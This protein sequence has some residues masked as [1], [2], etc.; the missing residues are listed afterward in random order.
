MIDKS[1]PLRDHS[2]C[3]ATTCNLYQINKHTYKEQHQEEGCDCEQLLVKEE[4]LTGALFREDSF[5]YLRLKGD[6][7]NLTYEIVELGTAPYIAI[8]HVWAD[9]LGNPHANSLHKCKLHHLRE[10]VNV[11]EP[12]ST[13]AEGEG[14]LIWLDTLCCPAKNGPGKQMAIEKI[15]LVYQRAK[16][17]LVLDAGLMAYDGRGQDATEVLVRIFTSSWMRR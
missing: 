13:H 7:H 8:S 5:P 4:D 12:M 14:P 11:I 2:R 9:G 17:V 16:H 10:L 6:L 15:R 1:F 3:T